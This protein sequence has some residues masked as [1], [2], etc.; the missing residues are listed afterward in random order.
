MLFRSADCMIMTNLETRF[1]VQKGLRNITNPLLTELV[2][3]N[4]K[5]N[6]DTIG[7]DIAPTIN[8]FTRVGTMEEKLDLFWSMV[9]CT[10]TK[11][12]EI[13]GQGKFILPINE[14]V[15]KMSSR[16]KSRQTTQIKKALESQETEIFYE[17]LPFT[18]CLLSKDSNRSLTGLIG[19]RLVEKYKKPAIVL[20]K[21]EELLRGSGRTT[22]TFQ[23]FKSFAR[24]LNIFSFCEGHEG[25]FGV[26]LKEADLNKL[27][28]TLPNIKLLEN[29]DCYLV[30]KAYYGKVSAFDIM[31][32]SEYND[33]FSRGFEKPIFY[34][35]LEVG[36]NEVSIVGRKKDT[37]RIK[38]DSISYVKFK[39]DEEEIKNIENTNIEKIKLVGTFEVNEWNE[40]LYPQVNIIDLE[41]EGTKRKGIFEDDTPFGLNTIN[42]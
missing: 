4:S 31:V 2:N 19:N 12:I 23:N 42:W 13:R 16:I 22:E 7:F 8:A 6:Y 24:S 33:F 21:D 28:E 32:V 5:G 26:G 10:F 35:E 1:Y 39:C 18:L 25:A 36:S 9:G 15:A 20:K 3:F 17:N 29:A 41:A 11:E 38:N 27:L 34:I 14:Y 37:I 30:D 40:R